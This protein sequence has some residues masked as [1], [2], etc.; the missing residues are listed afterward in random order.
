MRDIGIQAVEY[1]LAQPRRYAI[2]HHGNLRPD[3]VA[4]FFQAAHQFI[5]RF[6]FVRIRAEE[7]VLLYLIPRFYRQRDIAHLG[8]ATANHNT[9]FRGEEFLGNRPGGHAH[10]GFTRRGTTA[11]AIVAQT[12]FLLVGVVSVSRTENVLNGAVVLRTLVG[13]LN[14]QANAGPGGHALEYAGEDLHLVRL[15]ALGGIARGSRTTAIEIVLEIG[16]G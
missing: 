6:D 14:Q 9:E 5:K 15:A 1:R 12:I 8:Q 13:I 2:G 10:G 11:A 4:L 3:G 7:R 16:F